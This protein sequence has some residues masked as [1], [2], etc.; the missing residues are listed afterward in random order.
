MDTMP[1]TEPVSTTQMNEAQRAWFYAEYAVAR[2]DEIAGVLL[3]I[4]LG[5]FG[6]HH[7][8][9]RRYGLGVLYL[10]FSWTGIP[11]ILGWI[12]CFFMPGR[13][14]AYNALEASVI[15]AQILAY[16][17]PP[18]GPYVTPVAAPPIA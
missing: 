3:A 14:R 11:T 1:Y 4:F 9:L 2:R 6:V 5:G 10:V 15:A 13:V 16:P 17:T 8:Y 12:E 18:P 7:F